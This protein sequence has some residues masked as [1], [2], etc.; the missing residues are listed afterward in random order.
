MYGTC[1]SHKRSDANLISTEPPPEQSGSGVLEEWKDD[2][3]GSADTCHKMEGVCTVFL[4]A[5][6]GARRLLYFRTD[7]PLLLEKSSLFK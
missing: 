3:P 1:N 7:R 5:L 4:L 2:K 6:K